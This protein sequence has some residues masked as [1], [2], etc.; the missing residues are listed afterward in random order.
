MFIRIYFTSCGRSTTLSENAPSTHCHWEWIIL[1]P[2][3]GLIM[4]MDIKGL[5]IMT[6][7]SKIAPASARKWGLY[8]RFPSKKPLCSMVLMRGHVDLKEQG[9]ALW[10]QLLLNSANAVWSPAPMNYRSLVFADGAFQ[11][12]K[13]NGSRL[14]G[15]YSDSRFSLWLWNSF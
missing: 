6:Q 4:Y 5:L 12:N 9:N 3:C 11:L 2:T 7:F 1:P 10:S 15:G 8:Y 13:G 14:A